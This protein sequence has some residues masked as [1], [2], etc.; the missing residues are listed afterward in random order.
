MK[1]IVCEEPASPTT[2]R[3]IEI[4]ILKNN[5]DDYL[6][7]ANDFSQ[8]LSSDDE[9]TSTLI[10]IYVHLTTG[11]IMFQ[12]AAYKVWAKREFPPLKDFTDASVDQA[13]QEPI[14]TFEDTQLLFQNLDAAVS[15]L[16]ANKPKAVKNRKSAKST[17]DQTDPMTPIYLETRTEDQVKF[18]CATPLR[19][20]RNSLDSLLTP[21]QSNSIATLKSLVSS[22]EA[23]IVK[24]KHTNENLL[25]KQLSALEDK[26]TQVGNSTKVD[27]ELLHSR[28]Q[29]LEMENE[30]LRAENTKIKSE[31]SKLKSE[32]QSFKLK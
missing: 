31:S 12:G 9:T 13:P 19:K 3:D 10:T 22:I 30:T 23:N 26:I 18:S 21:R 27:S 28:L 16:P 20:R 25:L 29:D 32:L 4:N 11:V 6:P 24:L 5:T 15:C 2:L 14:L 7:L 17:T 8:N 1:W